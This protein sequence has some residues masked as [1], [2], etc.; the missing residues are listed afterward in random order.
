MSVSNQVKRILKGKRF[1]IK[2]V[3]ENISLGEK[4]LHYALR[5]ESLKVSTLIEI[6]NYVKVDSAK[7]PQ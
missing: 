2:D 7:T 4:G 1:T 3:S 6:A 5:K